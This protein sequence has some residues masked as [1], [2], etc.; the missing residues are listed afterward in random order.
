[1]NPPGEKA[2]LQEIRELE[3][4]LGARLE[5]VKKQAE[6]RVVDAKVLA[7]ETVKQKDAELKEL[8]SSF[9]AASDKPAEKPIRAELPKG[10]TEKNVFKK[11][12]EDL[13]KL[14]IRL[15]G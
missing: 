4:K 8:R 12:A 9:E 14:L 11:L 5:T 7:E 10:I 15:K 6:K 1:M 2:A 3:Q 13:F